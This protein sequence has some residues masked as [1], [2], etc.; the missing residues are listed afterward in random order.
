MDEIFHLAEERKPLFVRQVM[1]KSNWADLGIALKVQESA[2]RRACTDAL[3]KRSL[4]D[5]GSL[6]MAGPSKKRSRIQSKEMGA[7]LCR[8]CVPVLLHFLYLFMLTD[9]ERLDGQTNSYI[10]S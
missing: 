7:I 9:K 4:L 1:K 10:Q 2:G 8:H 3:S 6:E 5:S